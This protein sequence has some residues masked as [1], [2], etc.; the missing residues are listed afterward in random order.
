MLFEVPKSASFFS[1]EEA[2]SQDYCVS[3]GRRRNISA[4]Q[5]GEL[6]LVGEATD[7]ALHVTAPEPLPASATARR[8]LFGIPKILDPIK[9]KVL[10][11]HHNLSQ[12]ANPT[13]SRFVAIS[14]LNPALN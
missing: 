5:D 13:T 10:Q 11:I 9:S 7:D 12:P 8:R 3:K 2:R 14:Q 6:P 4:Y 1:A